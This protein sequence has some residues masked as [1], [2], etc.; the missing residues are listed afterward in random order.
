[1]IFIKILLN[2]DESIKYYI[3]FQSL[4]TYQTLAQLLDGMYRAASENNLA[5]AQEIN[6]VF[7]RSYDTLFPKWS[8]QIGKFAL[9]TNF[10]RARNAC[11]MLLQHEFSEADKM[12]IR[13]DYDVLRKSISNSVALAK[14]QS[15]EQLILV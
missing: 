10:D 8:R 6:S 13:G 3:A 2:S 12:N 15:G 9:P 4:M 1:M 14:K 5:K 7:S 11:L